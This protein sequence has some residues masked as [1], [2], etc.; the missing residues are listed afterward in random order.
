MNSKNFILFSDCIPVKGANRSVI[1]DLQNNK[2]HF[3]PNGLYEI[4]ETYNGKT[5]QFI[6]K[7]FNNSYDEIIDE[8]FEF[9]YS[10]NLI[11]YDANPDLFP[12]ISLDWN[13]PSLITN[14]IID[15]DAIEHDFE[16]IIK[17]LEILKCSCIQVRFF[18]KINLHRITEMVEL[19]N[20]LKSRIIS[21]DFIIPYSESIGN[22]E[23]EILIKK[24]PRIHSVIVFNA[25]Y[26]KSYNAIWEKMGYLMFVKRNILDEKHCGIINEEYFYSN[27]KLFSESHHHNTCLNR[28]ISI[29]KKGNIKN[30]PSMP[31]SFGNINDIT[32]VEALNLTDFKK[33]WNI[34]K[35][36][37]EV[38]KDCEFRYICTDC[39][40]YLENP[41]NQNSK[42]LKCGYDPYTNQWE[43][44]STNSLKEKAISYYEMEDV[45]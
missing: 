21:I 44:W 18:S 25:P 33:Y 11:F 1:C 12:K 29:D 2:Y 43:E 41:D 9:L 30:C 8:Y 3:I 38:C 39:R 6:K 17:Q 13:S 42:P 28:K 10:H 23:L 31:Q 34:T 7:E 32:L 5:I 27:I 24:N 45:F 20:E 22:E 19:L 14:M 26:D 15:Y 36:Q 37:I 4:L 35:D 40:A 16:N